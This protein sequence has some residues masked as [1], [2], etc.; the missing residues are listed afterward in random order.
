MPCNSCW[1][2][3]K[4]N[5]KYL[6]CSNLMRSAAEGFGHCPGHMPKKEISPVGRGLCEVLEVEEYGEFREEAEI[7]GA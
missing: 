6:F 3:G 1:W 2:L 5:G 7:G 4:G